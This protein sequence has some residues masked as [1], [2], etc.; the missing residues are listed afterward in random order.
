MPVTQT[1]ISYVVP[2]TP[3]T[4]FTP[5]PGLDVVWLAKIAR[6][7]DLIEQPSGREGEEGFKGEKDLEVSGSTSK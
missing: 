3:V 6:E 1:D 5:P 4:F 7:E 2:P